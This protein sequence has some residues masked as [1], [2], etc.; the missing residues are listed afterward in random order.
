MN[1]CE[2]ECVNAERKKKS[3]APGGGGGGGDQYKR[4]AAINKFGFGFGFRV[5]DL[6][7][8]DRCGGEAPQRDRKIPAVRFCHKRGGG[9][10]AGEERWG[11][12][13]KK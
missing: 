1:G 12:N 10:K 5:T 2:N 4:K 11:G 13:I 8:W 7:E 9:G 3:G 6:D